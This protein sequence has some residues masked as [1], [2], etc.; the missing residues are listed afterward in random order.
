MVERLGP[1]GTE[2]WAHA[3]GY[4]EDNMPARLDWRCRACH[5]GDYPC[6]F[7]LRKGHGLPVGAAVDQVA[8]V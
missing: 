3:S 8:W 6:V 1:R 2:E 5:E 7:L 4:F